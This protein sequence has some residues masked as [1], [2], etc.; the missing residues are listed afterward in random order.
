MSKITTKAVFKQ[1]QPQQGLLLPPSLDELIAPTHLVR[2]I[3]EAVNKMDLSAVINTYEGGGASAYHPVMMTKV[4][5][6]A[7]GMKIYTGRKIAQAL[8]Q[9]VTFMWLSA[10]NRPDFRTINEFRSG[11][12]KDTI[13]SLFKAVLV[14]LM[15]EG[16]I[17][18]ED[19]FCDGSTWRADANRHKMIWRKNAERYKAAAEKK[20]GQLFEQI[21]SLNEAEDKQYGDKDLETEGNGKE[22]IHQ[23]IDRQINKL[24]QIAAET[25]DK[26]RARKAQSLQKQI[27]ETGDKIAKYQNQED[28]AR[29]RGG[30]SQHDKDATAMRMKNQEILPAYN[31]MA[32][33]EEQFIT[34]FSVHQNSNDAACFKEH[35]ATVEQQAPK[36]PEN[37]NADSIFGT[38]ENYELLE[39]KKIN[40]YLKYP[41]FHKEQT[42]KHQNNPFLKENFPYDAATDSYTCPQ[43]QS[44]TF[45][46][47]VQL[48]GK[49]SGHVSTLRLYE[50]QNCAGCPFALQC[51]K[52]EQGRRTIRVNK[53]LDQY[54][55][56]A[57]SN[58]QSEKGVAMR[59]RRGC[60]IEPCFGDAKH[61]MKFQRFHLRGKQKVTTEAGI[62]FIAHNLRKVHLQKTEGL[63]KAA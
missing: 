54:K 7:Y 34:G 35:L 29:G 31:V 17:R 58:L 22:D 43:G 46:H 50:C 20:C 55:T 14:F 26:K 23:K 16:Y 1:Y 8:R 32:G 9:D 40:N 63:A 28:T 24:N 13:Q 52:D 44:L 59:K 3:N 38:E 25:P 61:N 21:E 48:P 5:L 10:M 49:K 18:F 33:S 51:K 15:E 12:L 42:R 4:M 45:Q 60:E 2:V 57:R 30:Y 37:I 36:L 41:T 56:Q 6:Y 53:K 39:E 11:R 62:L 19:Y 27:K 47:I